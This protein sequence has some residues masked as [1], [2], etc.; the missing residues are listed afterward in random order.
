MEFC[1]EEANKR[2]EGFKER[3]DKELNKSAK[4]EWSWI[5]LNEKG[6]YDLKFV[7]IASVG[8]RSKSEHV[9]G[10]KNKF[11]FI[12]EERIEITIQRKKDWFGLV[13]FYGISTIVGY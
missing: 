4:K 6:V 13:W 5:C 3:L 2:Q 11:F 10:K 9:E 1:Q 7:D 12:A 8:I